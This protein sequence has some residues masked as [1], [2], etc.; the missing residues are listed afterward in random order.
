MSGINQFVEILRNNFV[1]RYNIVG[2]FKAELSKK[3]KE[4]GKETDK[5]LLGSKCLKI[6]GREL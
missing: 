1:S 4:V 6:L 2:K 5:L 3:R